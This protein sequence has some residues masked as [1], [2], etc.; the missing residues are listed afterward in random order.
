MQYANCSFVPW[1]TSQL[2]PSLRSAPIISSLPQPCRHP[3]TL[4][5]KPEFHGHRTANCVLV[6]RSARKI[7]VGFNQHCHATAVP[8]STVR[9]RQWHNFLDRTGPDLIM[10]ADLT[11]SAVALF[12]ETF[13]GEPT[14]GAAAPGRVNLI[15]EHTDYC[16]GYVFPMVGVLCH[17]PRQ[18]LCCVQYTCNDST[19]FPRAIRIACVTLYICLPY[20]ALEHCAIMVGRPVDGAVCRCVD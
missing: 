7:S 12:K 16:D 4:V 15:G 2:L 13:K 8:C 19:W 6:E 17:D 10:A 20:Q 11:Q 1:S 14:F 3:C 18:N 9:K 5:R